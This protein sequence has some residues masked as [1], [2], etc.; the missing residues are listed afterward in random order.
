MKSNSILCL[1]LSVFTF[2]VSFSALAESTKQ[3]PI[4]YL[5]VKS[6]TVEP[7]EY[8]KASPSNRIEFPAM[9]EEIPRSDW[10]RPASTFLSLGASILGVYYIEDISPGPTDTE[11]GVL[12]GGSATLVT[13]ALKNLM[14][15]T[16]LD[17]IAGR[18][19]YNG[20]IVS[21]GNKITPS[22]SATNDLIIDT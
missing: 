16:K 18:T 14:L 10:N 20:A 11:T 1:A 13:Y 15:K 7:P 21:N 17:I 2:W 5:K 9:M 12:F 6:Q 19:N 8:K 22:T 3:N 4:P